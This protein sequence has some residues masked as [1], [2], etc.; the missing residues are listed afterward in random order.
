MNEIK[1]VVCTHKSAVLPLDDIF[2]PIQVGKAISNIDLPIQG[3][4]T[5]D[6]ISNKNKSFSELTALY[7]AWKNLKSI[8]PNI[9]YIGF[10]HYRRYLALNSKLTSNDEIRVDKLPE[11]DNYYD[12]ISNYL[13]SH[14]IILPRKII[15]PYSLA[16]SYALYHYSEDYMTLKE[17]F[18][19]F[20]P[21]YYGSFIYIFEKNNKL[22]PCNM[23]ITHYSHFVQYCEWL[24]PFLF[25]LEKIINID[26]YNEYQRRI[27]G[28]ISERLLN[29]F[30]YHNKIKSKYKPLFLI[31][32]ERQ[33]GK[34]SCLADYKTKTKRQIAFLFQKWA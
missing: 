1:I 34:H 30:V 17:T 16:T 14:Q 3:D 9:Q 8:Y 24:F 6:N 21:D 19:K 23:F 18:R 20:Y 28:F 26:H 22:S 27:Y 31:D 12:M 15:Y 10:S 13:K 29:V 7:W 33:N 11:F 4:N 25:Q 32:S 5:G 2:F